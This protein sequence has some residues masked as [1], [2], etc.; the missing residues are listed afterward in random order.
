[1]SGH[2]PTLSAKTCL[3]VLPSLSDE[4]LKH[5][6]Q[7]L[8]S[9]YPQWRPN[10]TDLNN[11]AKK[12]E[13]LR[14]HLQKTLFVQFDNTVDKLSSLLDDFSCAVETAKTVV[15][16]VTDGAMDAVTK[17]R[18]EINAQRVS[19]TTQ[20]SPDNDAASNSGNQSFDNPVS[21]CDLD[22]SAVSFDD[23]RQELA[24][25]T[26]HPGGRR[27]VYFG[28]IPYRYGR[29]EHPAKNYP[30]SQILDT[31]FESLQTIESDIRPENYSCL[32]TL[33]EDGSAGIPLHHDDEPAI[34]HDSSIY[35]VSF[36]AKRKLRVSNTVG[37]AVEYE[38]P[39][40]H[41]SV[42]T[43]TRSSQ[44]TWRHG[45]DRDPSINRP[46]ISLT[47][48][49][50]VTPTPTPKSG[51]IPVPP[52]APPSQQATLP[53]THTRHSRVL[54]IHD[55]MFQDTPE[56]AFEHV[57]GFTCVKRPNYQLANMFKFESEFR[58]AKTVIISCGV[59]DL[60]RYGET[61]K[62]LADT[63]C[64]RLV[65]CCNKFKGVNF[66]FTSITNSR[67]NRWLNDEIFRFNSILHDLARGLQNL[68]FFDAHGMI[69]R[70]G[71]KAAY[72]SNDRNGI[73]LSLE[74]RKLVTR[75]LASCV[76]KLAGSHLLYHRNFEWLYYI[77][78]VLGPSSQ[79]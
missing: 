33:Y 50:L 4:Q 54:L 49:K 34:A 42:Y 65:E 21:Q 64:P 5:E 28:S 46:R 68:M 3:I 19:N 8:Q 56:R 6:I 75:G 25:D 59:N 14:Q 71:P 61:A 60:S 62:S 73:H 27:T 31:V 35:T 63:V 74:V 7:Y 58:H 53:Q 72:D 70:A 47:F 37:P 22:L 41:G 36:G 18:A 11:K 38:V 78:T 10:K 29:F 40:P 76:G 23:L 26:D 52:V 12:V 55:S 2:I 20:S 45:I 17:A 43:M 16:D 69:S 13:I 44:D 79:Y 48:R 67:G 24:F 30:S 51:S 39:L 9:L 15:K 32:A 57:P 66:V 77:P 1:M